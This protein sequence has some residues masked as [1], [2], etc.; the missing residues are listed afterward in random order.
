METTEKRAGSVL[1]YLTA[2]QAAQG[3]I[4]TDCVTLD[5]PSHPVFFLVFL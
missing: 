4:D 1:E 2:Y 3:R 5:K